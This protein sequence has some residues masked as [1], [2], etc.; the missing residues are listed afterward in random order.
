M[1]GLCC[2]INLV[3]RVCVAGEVNTSVLPCT[4]SRST[5]TINCEMCDRLYLLS[6]VNVKH[7]VKA[8][9]LCVII[10]SLKHRMFSFRS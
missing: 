1:D 5:D 2:V 4:V 7:Y 3:A 8:A 9:G 6:N 10:L